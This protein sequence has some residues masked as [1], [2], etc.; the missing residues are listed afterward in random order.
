MRYRPRGCGPR[1]GFAELA[2][3]EVQPGNS[4][5]PGKVNPVIAE[6]LCMVAA[7][8]I[9]N[10]SD[11]HYCRAIRQLRTQRYDAGGRLLI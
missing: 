10:D 1:A 4:I 8:V 7:Q 5:M 3:P 11:D 2:L 6:A 9:G